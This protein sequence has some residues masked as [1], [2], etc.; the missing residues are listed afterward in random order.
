MNLNQIKKYIQSIVG[1][2]HV[3]FYKGIRNQNEKFEGVITKTFPSIFIIEL[4]NGKILS[5]N[6][7][8]FIIKNI[9][10]LY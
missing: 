10:I 6:Y 4:S 3:F 2:K 5:F 8:D 9:K 1:E 7:N